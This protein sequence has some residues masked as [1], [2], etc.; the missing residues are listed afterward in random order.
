MPNQGKNAE[1]QCSSL[2]LFSMNLLSSIHNVTHRK[3][4]MNYF[5]YV[6]WKA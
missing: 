6:P 5:N 1:S 4:V 3:E 2:I